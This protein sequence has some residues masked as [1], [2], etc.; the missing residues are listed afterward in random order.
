M[1]SL[2]LKSEVWKLKI[3]AGFFAILNVFFEIMPF[4]SANFFTTIS[5][6]WQDW[7]GAFE[8][9]REKKAFGDV[10]TPDTK[11]GINSRT[12]SL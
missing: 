9:G 10:K 5:E 7:M 3:Q 2:K 1:T 11:V 6:S 12:C 4:V 8:G